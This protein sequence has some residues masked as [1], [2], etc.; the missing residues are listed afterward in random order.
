M[1]MDFY[2]PVRLV[3]GELCVKTGGNIFKSYGSK[4]LIVTGGRS[5]KIS[6]AL[7]A[8]LSVLSEKDISYSIYSEI[9]ENPTVTS[10]RIGGE[11]AREQNADF[12]IGIGGGSPLD[13]AKAVAIFAANEEFRNEDIYKRSIPA[14]ALPVLLIGTTSGTGSEVTGVSV[15]TDDAVNM[16][17]SISGEDC[18]AN[19]AFL[20]PRFT[21]TMPLT[22]TIS[23][24][25]DAL[26]HTVEGW[27]SPK[28]SDIAKSFG[29]LAL[30]Q[31]FGQ[32]TDIYKYDKLP[33]KKGRDALFYG[34]IYSGLSLNITGASFAHTLGYVLTED[35]GISHGRACTA[36]MPFLIKRAGE[37]C[38]NRLDEML[39]I[40]GTDEDSFLEIVKGLT[41]IRL[42]ISAEEIEKYCER[43]DNKNK[44]F[45]NSP[46]G[47]TVSD[48]S[49]ALKSLSE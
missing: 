13:A 12:I 1:N 25:L 9:A 36:F 8:V 37:F 14:K 43:W 33:N 10:C 7:H 23:T 11:K 30:G 16:K 39:N 31:I 5:A 49:L 27:F 21:D 35:F 24:G 17:K 40:L 19:V 38:K 15:L 42:N 44:N 47:F 3:S 29:T 28:R 6:G 18:Y 4:C 20:N 45:I 32:L 46:G 41:N 26:S 2:M 22:V 34:S 48:V